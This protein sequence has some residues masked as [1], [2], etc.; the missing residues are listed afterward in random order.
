MGGVGVDV[1]IMQRQYLQCHQAVTG[2][3]SPIRL[4]HASA[5]NTVIFTAINTA[6]TASIIGHDIDLSVPC[7][8]LRIL[9]VI[10]ILSL[11]VIHGK[12]RKKVLQY[13]TLT[14]V[15]I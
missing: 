10:G 3:R 8:Q 5:I 4:D 14:V 13:L 15:P 6:I 9:M 12:R 11:T 7:L 2:I 1:W